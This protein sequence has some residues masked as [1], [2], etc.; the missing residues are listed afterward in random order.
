MSQ[1][2]NLPMA[3]QTESG[4][5]RNHKDNVFRLLFNDKEHALQLYNAIS[6]NHYR[7]KAPFRFTTLEDVILKTKKNDIA[8]L[9]GDAFIIMLEHQS[10]LSKSLTIRY[11]LYYATTIQREFP[12]KDF[13]KASGLKIP[14]PTFIVL[15]NG[16]EEI[17]DTV[18]MQ[19]SDNFRGKGKND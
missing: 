9:L 11:L 2:E 5:L 7:P 4:L 12:N 18:H 16:T 19:L 10:T 3:N 17:P 13:Y 14:R 15:Y 8:F 6:G 1:K